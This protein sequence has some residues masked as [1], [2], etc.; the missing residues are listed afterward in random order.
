MKKAILMTGAFIMLMTT[1][2]LGVVGGDRFVQSVNNEIYNGKR[3]GQLTNS[4]ARTLRNQLIQYE[5]KLWEYSS[6]GDLTRREEKLLNRLE[7]SLVE[8]LE[9]LKYNRVT[10]R[11]ERYQ[12]QRGGYYGTTSR[13]GTYYGTATSRRRPRTTTTRTRPRTSNRGGTYCPPPRRN[14]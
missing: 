4:E 9:D 7:D 3:T 14:W 10:V 5:D 8:R 12:P 13:P 2:A 1:M 11:S 6:Y